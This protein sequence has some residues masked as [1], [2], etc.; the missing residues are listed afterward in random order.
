MHHN[1]TGLSAK[2][3]INHGRSAVC[4][5]VT[6][7]VCFVSGAQAQTK[8]G[9]DLSGLT[10]DLKE[11]R[12][13]GPPRDGIPSIDHPKFI[14]Q[15]KVDFLRDDDIVI[16]LVRGNTARAY[17]TRILIWHEIVNDVIGQDAVAVTYCPLCGTAMVFGRAIDGIKR[18]FGVSGLLYRS[19]VLM[20]DR[21]SESL[22]SQLAMKAVSGP[23]V[24]KALPW[25]P[26]EHLTF[27]AWREKYPKGQVLSTDTGVRRNYQANAYASYFASDKT[28]FPVPHTRRELSN[29]TRVIG[30]V[31]GGKAK[32]YVLTDLSTGKAIQDT[33]ADKQIT[34]R[35]DTEKQFPQVAHRTGD[36]IPSVVVFWFAWQAFYP[37]TALW[38]PQ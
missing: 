6:M 2:Q 35:Y 7:W 9:F 3:S 13:G 29:K 12:S 22:W 14:A 20:Y 28:M 16:G 18:T 27:K 10:I 15:D 4:C 17:P 31:I 26:S 34:V 23:A 30:V 8:N 37:D 11:L 33:V 25:L 19:D 21:Q 24:G 36:P 1:D 32:A 5:A 38:A